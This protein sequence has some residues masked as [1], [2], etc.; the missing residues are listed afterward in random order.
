MV[1]KNNAPGRRGRVA[2]HAPCQPPPTCPPV[3]VYHPPGFVY[4]SFVVSVF[5]AQDELDANGEDKVAD[6]Q[7]RIEIRFKQ[8]PPLAFMSLLFAE[9]AKSF[10]HVEL[11]LVR[12]STTS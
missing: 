8:S 3:V 6:S 10:I 4:P 1:I 5:D 12:R 7:G 11:V 9:I 2:R